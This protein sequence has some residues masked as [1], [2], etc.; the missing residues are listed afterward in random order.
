VE[1]VQ[2]VHQQNNK[3][4]FYLDSRVHTQ[5]PSTTYSLDDATPSRTPSHLS[6]HHEPVIPN[7]GTSSSGTSSLSTDLVDVGGHLAEVYPILTSQGKHAYVCPSCT[8]N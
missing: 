3:L 5:L 4:S 6:Q 8:K 7:G 1:A 2:I